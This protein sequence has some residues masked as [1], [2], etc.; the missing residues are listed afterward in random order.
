MNVEQI[1]NKT[2]LFSVDYSLEPKGAP[3]G[4]GYYAQSLSLLN[5]LFHE[6]PQFALLKNSKRELLGKLA[7]ACNSLAMVL[8]SELTLYKID[9][10]LAFVLYRHSFD[11]S[12]SD[13]SF[14]RQIADTC[15]SLSFSVS[16]QLAQTVCLTAMFS[17]I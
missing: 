3:Q 15:T 12:E 13:L 9:K 16:T 1:Q 11:L 4:G 2:E 7:S 5:R 10:N 14:M 6:D 17:L 8:K